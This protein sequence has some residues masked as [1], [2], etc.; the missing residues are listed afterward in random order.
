MFETLPIREKPATKALEPGE[1]YSTNT[2]KVYQAKMNKLANETGIDTV[3]KLLI[4]TNQQKIVKYID[5]LPGSNYIHRVI[6]SAVF[7]SIGP[8]QGTKEIKILYDAFKKYKV[9]DGS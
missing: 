9:P 4:P 3:E 5:A 6:Y 1:L 2:V 7:Y 8:K